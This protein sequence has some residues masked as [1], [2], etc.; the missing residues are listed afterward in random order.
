MKDLYR[1]HLIK[2]RLEIP[3]QPNMEFLELHYSR[4]VG[5]PR[6]CAERV[7]RFLGRPLDVDAMV[8]AVDKE[9]YRNRKAAGVPAS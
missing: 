7:K 9:L 3:A 1:N 6:E 5:D 4:V 2:V 8:A